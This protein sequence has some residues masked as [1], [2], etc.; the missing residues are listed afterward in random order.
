MNSIVSNLIV[1]SIED[2]DAEL[3]GEQPRDR[4][5]ILT[6][7]DMDGRADSCTVFAEGFGIATGFA[8]DGDIVYLAN[9]P[10]L[11]KLSDTDGDGKAD[12]REVV[13]TGFSMPDSHH[14]ISVFEWAPD[15]GFYM[16]EG[17]FG[18]AAVETPFGTVRARDGA[19]WRFEPSTGHLQVLS[20]C[21]YPNPWGHVFDDFGASILDS[22]S[23]GEHF[24]FSHVSTAFELLLPPAPGRHPQYGP[25][26]QTRPAALLD[27]PHPGGS[28]N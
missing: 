14:Q 20:H 9:A 17:T 22:T 7:T 21:Y 28:L 6:D 5:V 18:R 16:H 3:P 12:R 11:L 25:P 27:R 23:G 24:Y 26:L 13:L 15:G 2:V 19:V 1:P 8:I 10:D 4:L